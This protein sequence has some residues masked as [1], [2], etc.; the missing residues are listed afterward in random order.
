MS[1]SNDKASHLGYPALRNTLPTIVWGLLALV[2]LAGCASTKVT[3]Q[4]RLVTEKL[5]RPGHIL[6]YD[7][8]ATLVPSHR[9]W[10]TK[11][12]WRW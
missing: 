8:S 4:E 2:V 3:S 11:P 9:R 7:F 1:D 10:I 12:N 6:V 5:P